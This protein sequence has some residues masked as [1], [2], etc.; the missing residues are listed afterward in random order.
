MA[1]AQAPGRVYRP[2]VGMVRPA[3]PDDAPELVRLRAVMLGAMAGHTRPCRCHDRGN[4]TTVPSGGWQAQAERTLRRRLSEP[5]G[6]M[7]ALVVD[8][9][10]RPGRLAACV[11]GV[12][13]QRLSGPDNPTGAVGYVFSVATDPERRRRGYSRACMVRLLAWFAQRGITTVD[14]R[15]S[16]EGEPLYRSLGFVRTSDPAMR[17]YLGP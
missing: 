2:R 14:L 1:L 6:T 15:A 16:A 12:I 4:P 8:D 11:V 17:L 13:E 3:V 10:E 7:T 5:D 9:P